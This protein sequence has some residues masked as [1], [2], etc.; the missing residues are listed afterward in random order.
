MSEAHAPGVSLFRRRGPEIALIVLAALVFCGR[1]GAMDLW[2][3]REQRAVA[4]ALNTVDENN[5]LVAYIQ[6]RP[7]LEKPPLP[8][9]TTA[10]LMNATGVRSEWLMRLPNALS[11][12]AIVGLVYGL[13]R[14]MAGRDV[15]LASGLILISTCFFVVES[16][17]AG[18]DGPLALFTT[19]ALYAAFRRL[20]GV[21]A[22]EPPGVPAE[23]LGSKGWAVVCWAAMGLG[24]LSKGPIA[25]I[26]PAF[27]IVPYLLFSRRLVAGGMA[28]ASVSG[29]LAFLLLSLSWP[30]SVVI[31]N[32]RAA[33]VWWLEMGQKAG[34]A[35]ITH[36]R[37]RWLVSDWPWMTVPWTLLA[38]WGVVAPFL[39]RGREAS[40]TTLLAWFWGVANLAMFCVWS[41]AKPNYYVPCEPGLAILTGIAWVNVMRSARDAKSFSASRS[42]RFVQLHWVLLM[43]VAIVSAG[44][45]IA[46]MWSVPILASKLSPEIARMVVA[47]VIIGC[48]LLAVGVIG[49]IVAWRKLADSFVLTSLVGGITLAVLTGYVGVVPKFNDS[50]SHRVLAAELDRVLPAD[51]SKVMFFRQLDEGL[52]FYLKDRTLVGVPGSVPKYS[53]GM[54][55]DEA[56]KNNTLIFDDAKRNQQERQILVDWLEGDKHESPYVLIRAKVFD[57]Y[58]PGIAELAEPIFREIDTERSNPLILLRVREKSTIARGVNTERK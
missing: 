15:G 57:L 31:S 51:I 45:V 13:G 46:R 52:W 49:S 3:K 39:G 8:R 47:P 58:S 54:D 2:G 5:W 21:S 56:A 55:L 19:L 28:L 10:A 53:I 34:A 17:Q 41:V 22:D 33:D 29:I 4:E 24:F 9:W 48:L 23:H 25:V 38:T 35:G 32:P 1:L 50:K 18:N 16:R 42:R 11:A 14:R 37:Q 44:Y 43:S 30:V 26:L 6:C 27:A 40:G 36:H 12:L 20:H 7:R